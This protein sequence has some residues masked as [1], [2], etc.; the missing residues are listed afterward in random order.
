M[1][2]IILIFTILILNIP[3]QVVFASENC[4]KSNREAFLKINNSLYEDYKHLDPNQNVT[5]DKKAV[6]IEGDAKVSKALFLAHGFMGSPG[7]MM[8]IAKPFIE[9]GWTVVGFLLPGHGST[10]QIANNYKIERSV[11]ELKK[12]LNLVTDCFDEVRAVGFSTGGLLLHQYALTQPIP[13][14]LKSL[15]LISP[16]VLQK[17]SGMFVRI[18]GFFV[19][20]MSIDTAYF[21]SHFRDLKVMTLDRQYYHHNIPID[22]GLQ[23]KEL[24]KQVY[25]MKIQSRI[26]IP[27]QLFLSEGDMTV[28][29]NVTKEVFNRDF[30][31]VK[32]VWYKGKEPH[33]LMAPSVSSVASDVQQLIYNFK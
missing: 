25:N 27:V 6:W 9:Q 16:F 33:H 32:L 19:N 23:I 3:N 7:E 18:L 29:T 22:S 11:E 10:Y 15:H 20:G 2:A 12:Q 26:K 1:K 30:E 5:E 21:I 31:D 17:F 14:S 4:R 28:D 8:F 13:A 24:G